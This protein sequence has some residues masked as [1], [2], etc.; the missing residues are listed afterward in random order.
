MFFKRTLLK[1][2]GCPVNPI[3]GNYPKIIWCWH[4]K[5]LYLVIKWLFTWLTGVL[6]ID[7]TH[8]KKCLSK[9]PKQSIG[10][11][12]RHFVIWWLLLIFLGR[13]G[14][15]E[16]V[17]EL[18]HV[19]AMLRQSCTCWVYYLGLLRILDQDILVTVILTK[20]VLMRWITIYWMGCWINY[21]K[22]GIQVDDKNNEVKS[23]HL[24]CLTDSARL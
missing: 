19:A 2:G 23:E 20:L 17:P 8:V 4:V 21:L 15:V 16:L 6:V 12:Y 14:N 3:L 11:Y 10:F 18:Q 7:S 13:T 5:S 1:G 22:E 24:L 9:S